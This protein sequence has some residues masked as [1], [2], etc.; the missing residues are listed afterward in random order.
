MKN[1]LKK[2]NPWKAEDWWLAGY[3]LDGV[4]SAL[5][6]TENM[7][8][9]DIADRIVADFEPDAHTS[10]LTDVEDFAESLELHMAAI[11]REERGDCPRCGKSV[12]HFLSVS[13]ICGFCSSHCMHDYHRFGPTL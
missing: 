10:C 1:E 3:S 2:A 8:P 12:E 9:S 4:V 13:A 6:L 5:G 11:G 7:F